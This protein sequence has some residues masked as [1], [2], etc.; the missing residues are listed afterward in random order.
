M[1]IQKALYEYSKDHKEKFPSSNNQ[2]V[3]LSATPAPRV[4]AALLSMKYHF[5]MPK[6]PQGTT[7]P[8]HY[9]YKSAGKLNYTIRFCLEDLQDGPASKC[10][11]AENRKYCNATPEKLISEE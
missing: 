8:C 10:L 5:A 11:I 3:I 9:Y 2:W 7:W 4:S 1:T 6:D